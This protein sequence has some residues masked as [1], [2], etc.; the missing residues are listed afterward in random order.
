MNSNTH[1]GNKLPSCGELKFLL[2]SGGV[3][4]ELFE[5]VRKFGSLT[6]SMDRRVEE[7]DFSYSQAA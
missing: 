3:E 7:I 4:E 6:T 5:N 2:S 1:S